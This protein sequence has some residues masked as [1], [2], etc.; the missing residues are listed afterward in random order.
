M[1]WLDEIIEQIFRTQK[2]PEQI[3]DR[4]WAWYA[5]KTWEGV[6]SGYGMQLP[7]DPIDWTTPDHEMLASLRQNTWHF[8]AAKTYQQLRAYTNALVDDEGNLRSK[9]QFKDAAASITGVQVGPWLDAEYGQAVA[10]SQMAGK[11]VNIQENKEILPI[12]EYDAVMDKRTSAICSSFDKIRL[13][14]DDEFWDKYYPPN[15]WGPCRS[16]VRQ[17]M[18]G[19][20]TDKSKIIY[21]E[22]GIPKMFQT[23]LAKQG[24]VF[25]PEHPYYIGLPD[26][27]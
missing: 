10:G 7:P 4:V 22:K 16:T 20:T 17:Q 26:N 19:K 27:L 21:P 15:H 18:E 25:P 6:T 14:A 12:L 8:S 9:S 2:M 24:L 5:N 1:N 23:N 3:D 11:W 13:Y